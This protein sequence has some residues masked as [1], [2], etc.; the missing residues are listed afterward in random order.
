MVIQYKLGSQTIVRPGTYSTFQ[1][2]GSTANVTPSPRNVLIVGEAEEGKPFNEEDLKNNFYT[3]LDEV[4]NTYGSG[5]IVD[6]C[7]QLFVTQPSRVFSGIVGRVYIAKTNQSTA[8][9]R[10]IDATGGRTYATLT[11]SRYGLIGNYIKSQIKEGVAESLPSATFAW[12]P[13]PTGLNLDVA[14]NGVKE[15]DSQALNVSDISTSLTNITPTSGSLTGGEIVIPD[16]ASSTVSLSV[17]GD[18]VEFSSSDFAA[19]PSVGDSIYIPSTSSIAG[20]SSE[21]VGSYVVEAVSSAAFTARKLRSYDGAGNKI[22]FVQPVDLVDIAVAPADLIAISSIEMEVT[23]S[24]KDGS[25]AVLELADDSDSIEMSAELFH[26]DP[27]NPLDVN[28]ANVGSISLFHDTGILTVQLIDTVWTVRPQVGSIVHIPADSK[29]AGATLK[30]VGLH[31]VTKVSAN[32]LTLDRLDGLTDGESVSAVFLAGETDVFT[33]HDSVVSNGV[34][35]KSHI[36]SSEET[37]IF[38]A[39]NNLADTTFTSEQIGGDI[40]LHIS[41]GLEGVTL[42]VDTKRRMLITN[43]STVDI[44]IPLGKFSSLNT[45]AD[46][47][48]TL[49]NIKAYA[50]RDLGGQPTSILD[51]VQGLGISALTTS[52]NGNVGRIKADYWS[53]S[54]VFEDSSISFTEGTLIYKAGLP[55]VDSNAVFFSGGSK[56]G[57]S[58]LNVSQALEN[59]IY[60]PVRLAIPLFSRD[61]V[62]DIEDL[63]TEDTSTYDIE[64]IHAALSGH[65]STASNITNQKER[66]G[67]IS[68]YGSYEDTKDRISA[69]NNYLVSGLAF[70]QVRTTDGLGNINWMLP[71]IYQ[72]MVA[73]GRTQSLL[74]TSMLNKSFNISDVRHI[75]DKSLYSEETTPEF[76]WQNN[77]RVEDAIRAGLL[78]LGEKSGVQGIV[79]LSPD[80]SS[81]SRINDPK[82]F[83]YER[84]NVAFI[85]HELMQTVRS[86]LNN[87]IGDRTSDVDTAT[88]RAAIESTI[89]DTFVS[90]GSVRQ[91]KVESVEDLGNG[92]NVKL[93]YVPVETLEFIGLEVSVTREL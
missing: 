77:K 75:G 10:E 67:L 39:S 57:T 2:V 30:N 62:R 69:V 32:T 55:I 7:A 47:L 38:D 3:S 12:L 42:S 22:V 6:A 53:F 43:G 64:S 82:A 58:S 21:N 29:I 26:Y 85:H 37:V 78:V 74:G 72:C 51:E 33:I 80:L 79:Q 66:L 28:A 40:A 90:G 1:V 50:D 44:T 59:S 56:G 34:K 89:S 31:V 24:N 92:Y 65:V 87:Y 17:T 83:F 88:V 16:V 36:S 19:L 93:V 86:V 14:V 25:G 23:S 60:L 8:A 20:G 68:F 70:M 4:R 71:H 54:E 91:Y 45:L 49:P 13:Q 18:L 76:D 27:T 48:N 11:S 81:V 46:Y 73:A 52:H 35:H 61:A 15:V 9:F 5:P 84:Q 63:I 41:H